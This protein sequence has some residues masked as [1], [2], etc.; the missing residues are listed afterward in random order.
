MW[1]D[2]FESPDSFYSM[3]DFQDDIDC[4]IRT[5]ETLFTNP[6]IHIYINKI[7]NRLVLIIKNGYEIEL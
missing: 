1:N 6:S 4:T 2:E 5:H 7:N 3:S